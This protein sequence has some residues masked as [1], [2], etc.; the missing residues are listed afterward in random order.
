MSSRS[1]LKRFALARSWLPIAAVLVVMVMVA[2][3][4]MHLTPTTTS[5]SQSRTTVAGP[6]PTSTTRPA[7]TSPS[8]AGCPSP[9]GADTV[10]VG[11]LPVEAL[12]T[13]EL[14]ASDGP[15]PYR[16]DDG[17]FSNREKML[18]N[19]PKGYYREYTVV[20]PGSDDR[21][22]R[23]VIAGDCGDQWYTD[24]HYASFRLIVGTP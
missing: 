10:D 12:D 5:A 6:S 23:R 16:Q 14:I 7:Q 13:L 9:S 8:R 24:D 17:V 4:Q 20:T 1:G 21:G 15:Y 19:H 18:P 11:E 22:A 3:S 2:W